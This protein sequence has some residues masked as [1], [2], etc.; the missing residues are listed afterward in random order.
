MV[1]IK[2]WRIALPSLRDALPMFLETGAQILRLRMTRGVARRHRDVDRW[3]VMLVQTKGFPRQALDAVAR[4]GAAEGTCCNRQAQSWMT[5]IVGQNRQ[6]K[7]GVGQSFAALPYGAKLGR[8]VQT[9]ARL[10]LQPI[11]GLWDCKKVRR[12]QGQRSLRPFARRRASNRRPLLVAMRARKPCVRA[13]C[14]LLGLKV[15][16]IAQLQE[17]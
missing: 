2:S 8:L 1:H 10:E 13:R 9:L 5:F 16:F 14:K 12:N 6:T 17:I 3:Q 11:D 15:R 4:Y 7:E